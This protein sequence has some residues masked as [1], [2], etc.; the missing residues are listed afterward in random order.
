MNNEKQEQVMRIVWPWRQVDTTASKV[1][2]RPAPQKL[3]VELL[4][5]VCVGLLFWFLF[6]KPTIAV[7]VFTLAA[8][9]F[10]TGLF[11]PPFHYA[12]KKA[13]QV[14]ASWVGTALTWVLLLPFFYIFFT[15]GRLSQLIFRKDPMNR[16]CPTKLDTYWIKHP[17]EVDV[18]SYTRQY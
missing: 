13:F 3:F 2:V 10:F 7:V 18:A 14:F 6:K 1:V 5:T 11:V 16:A 8:Y 15:I 17:A 12:F 9:T 4:I